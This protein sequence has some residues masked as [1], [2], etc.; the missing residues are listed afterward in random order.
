MLKTLA[1]VIA[2]YTASHYT[3]KAMSTITDSTLVKIAASFTSAYMAS[4]LTEAGIDALA[5]KMNR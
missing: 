1:Q 3:N 5:R 4:R 2:G